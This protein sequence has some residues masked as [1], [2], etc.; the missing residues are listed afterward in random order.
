[1]TTVVSVLCAGWDP[2]VG[3][4]R[5]GALFA[6][7]GMKSTIG[8]DENRAWAWSMAALTSSVAAREIQAE[9]PRTLAIRDLFGFGQQGVRPVHRRP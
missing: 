9:P 4:R 1:M 3:E 7:R 6:N 8:L 5:A 2:P